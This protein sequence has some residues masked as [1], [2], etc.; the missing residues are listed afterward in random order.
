VTRAELEALLIQ[1]IGLRI[2][3]LAF[4]TIMAAID[5]YVIAETGRIEARR[6]ALAEVPANGEDME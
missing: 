5:V 1:I 3:P 2:P 6:R 4:D